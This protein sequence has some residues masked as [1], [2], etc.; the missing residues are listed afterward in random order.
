MELK[1]K[2][3]KR[4]QQLRLNKGLKQSELA[5]LVGIAPKT[6]SFIET[7]RN[8]PSA[9]LIEKYAIAFNVDV[10]EVLYISDIQKAEDDY[11]YALHKL[12][13]NANEKQIEHI[14]KH[15]KLVMEG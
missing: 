1:K 4:I 8:F 3:G 5:D 11:L 2:L 12:I 9:N 7:G 13:N 6:Q 10:A 15:A 14:Y